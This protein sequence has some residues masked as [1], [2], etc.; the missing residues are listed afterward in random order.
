MRTIIFSY[1]LT[2]FFSTLVIILLWLQTRKRL[3]GTIFFVIDFSFQSVALILIVLRGQ[4]PDFLSIIVANLLVVIGMFLGLVGFTRFLN[5]KYKQLFNYFLVFVFLSI[6]LWFTYI[7]PDQIMRNMNTSV[8]GLV[9]FS[10]CAAVLLF[11]LNRRMLKLTLGVG[12]VFVLYSLINIVRVFSFFATNENTVDYLESGTFESLVMISYQVLFILLTYFLV[13]MV[14]KRLLMDIAYQEEKFSIAFH[15]SPYAIILTRISDGK[16][17]E[18]NDGFMKITGYNADEIKGKSTLDLLIWVNE[19]DRDEVIRELSM[20]GKLHGKEYQFRAESGNSITGLY[21]AE[22][23]V[24][25]DEECLL[26]IISDISD[27]KEYEEKIKKLNEDLELRVIERTSQLQSANKNLEAF[28]YTASHDLRTPLRA[29]NGYASLLLEDHS[30][31]INA[32]GNRMLRLIIDNANKMGRLIDDLLSFSGIGQKEV[33]LQKLD[34]N[35]MAISAWHEIVPAAE[36]VKIEFRL[37]SLPEALG[38]YEMIRQVWLNLISNAVKFSSRK[39]NPVIEI[40]EKKE[41]SETIYYV[42][43]NGVGFDMAHADKLFGVFKR[44]PSTKDYEG[45][46]VGLAIVNRVVMRHKGRVWAEG[47]INEGATFYFSLPVRTGIQGP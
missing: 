35:E 26:S 11:N 18:V 2:D 8:I 36:S 5:I 28:S 47:K 27:R 6:H 4:I 21:S 15:S 39:L 14:N 43:D 25:N 1:I 19:G 10:Q 7:Q 3:K 16:I 30:A 22:K 41:L 29:L 40:G 23:I 31:S 45:T 13:L 34:M 42:H 32:E 24:L 37:H 12:I 44:L 38:D 33:V 46:G 20:Q 9:F 17:L